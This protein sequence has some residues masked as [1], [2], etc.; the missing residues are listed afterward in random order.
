MKKST[1]DTQPVET[2]EEIT[3]SVIDT[4]AVAEIAAMEPAAAPDGITEEM[5]L[6]KVGFGLSRAQAIEVLQS[7]AAHD[8]ALAKA[9]KN[10]GKA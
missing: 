3:P 2:E 5:I 1:K 6:A 4:E 9:E 7:Q 8:A 10:K